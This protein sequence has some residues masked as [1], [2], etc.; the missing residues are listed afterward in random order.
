MAELF[1]IALPVH[2][3]DMGT[4]HFGD[5]HIITEIIDLP[6]FG[7]VDIGKEVEVIAL[8][9][10]VCLPKGGFPLWVERGQYAPVPSQDTVH[11]GQPVLGRSPPFIV[12]CSLAVGITEL[13]SQSALDLFIAV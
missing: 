5:A 3:A 4:V 8:F 6:F 7:A 1:H 12:V 2:D 10:E 13:F 11:F 9:Q